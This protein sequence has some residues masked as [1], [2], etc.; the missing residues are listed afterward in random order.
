VP[1]LSFSYSCQVDN[2]PT[3]QGRVKILLQGNRSIMDQSDA[4]FTVQRPWITLDRPNDGCR[5]SSKLKINERL[6][7]QAINELAA[8]LGDSQEERNEN[9]DDRAGREEEFPGYMVRAK[10]RT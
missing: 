3:I 5:R 2:Y 4:N 9:Q 8:F 10:Q 6:Q 7:S 1:A